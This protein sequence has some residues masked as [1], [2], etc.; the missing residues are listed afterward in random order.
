MPEDELD[1]Y[2]DP[3]MSIGFRWKYAYEPDEPKI[4]RYIFNGEHLKKPEE[5]P[6]TPKAGKIFDTQELFIYP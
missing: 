3:P 6:H 2:E 4:W 1:L 5:L